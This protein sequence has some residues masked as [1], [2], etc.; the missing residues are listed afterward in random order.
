MNILENGFREMVLT[1]LEKVA[2]VRIRYIRYEIKSF[3]PVFLIVWPASWGDH[4]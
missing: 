2:K 4:T 3:T 1:F